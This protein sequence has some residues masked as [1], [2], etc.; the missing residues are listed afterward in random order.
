MK[1]WIFIGSFFVSLLLGGCVTTAHTDLKKN[2]REA[3][4]SKSSAKCLTD[5]M[6]DRLSY[7]D[8]QDVNAFINSIEVNGDARSTIIEQGARI[9]NPKA[10]AAFSRANL[11][12]V[13]DE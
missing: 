7:A 8:L 2:L 12:C 11:A 5:E 6:D 4:F 9:A 10:A 13:V 3:G 1:S